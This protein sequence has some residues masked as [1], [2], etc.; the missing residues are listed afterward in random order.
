MTLTKDDFKKLRHLWFDYKD[1]FKPSYEYKNTLDEFLDSENETLQNQKLRE[2]MEEELKKVNKAIEERT[3][4]PGSHHGSFTPLNV[5][6]IRFREI[7]K[8]SKK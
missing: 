8:E 7:L 6:Q 4:N 2:L 3:L 5:I 1:D